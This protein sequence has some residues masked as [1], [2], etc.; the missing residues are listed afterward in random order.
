MT[1]H[2]KRDLYAGLLF[3][4][5]GLVFLI[6]AQDYTL[7]N[8]RRMGPGY[9]PAIL[10]AL[11]LGLGLLVLGMA[12]F[13][14]NKDDEALEGTDCVLLFAQLLPVAGFIVAAPVS[15][16]F[17]SLASPESSWRERITLTLVLTAGTIL[18]FRVGL[19]M[20]FPLLPPALT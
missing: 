15:L 10:G 19:E 16:I 17:S 1:L 3:S 5:F 7:G 14:G 20:R 11:Q 9:F 6:I 8:S 18:V 4:A 13:K 12:F 2:N